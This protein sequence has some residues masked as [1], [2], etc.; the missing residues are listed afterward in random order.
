MIFRSGC[1]SKALWTV[2]LGQ[3]GGDRL[4]EVEPTRRDR[5]HDRRR[6]EQLRHRLDA[7]D[8]VGVHGS[9]APLRSTWPKPSTHSVSFPSTRATARPGMPCSA[10]SSGDPTA[11]GRDDIRDGVGC[12][13]RRGQADCSGR[14]RGQPDARGERRQPEPAH[15][16]EPADHRPGLPRATRRGRHKEVRSG[17]CRR[18]HSD[19]L[20]AR[21]VG[22]RRPMP[23][24]I[25]L[26][27][28]CRQGRASPLPPAQFT[29]GPLPSD[30]IPAL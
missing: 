10:I 24:S 28:R 26:H 23:G 22:H 1:S 19:P 16:T 18:S 25:P 15:H 13:R 8:R 30:R 4:V 29:S 3:I 17:R 2:K 11:I 14:A 21:A 7:E 9:G 5:L 12:R 27:A 20:G 6:R